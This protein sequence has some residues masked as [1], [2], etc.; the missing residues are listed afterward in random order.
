[1]GEGWRGDIFEIGEVKCSWDRTKYLNNRRI[2]RRV[3][4]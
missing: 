4:K 2:R 3:D 1:M